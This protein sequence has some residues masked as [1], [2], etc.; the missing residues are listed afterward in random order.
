[1]RTMGKILRQATVVRDGF[2]NAFTDLQYWQSL[3]WVGYRK[4][5]GHV[6]M[7]GEIVIGVSADRARFREAARIKLYG[8][9]R[10][11]KLF[12]VSGTRCAVTIPTWEGG[13]QSGDL[14]QYIAFSEDGFHWSK[15]ERILADGEWLWRI[16][17]HKGLYYGLVQKLT[18]GK[19]RRLQHNLVLMTST[20]LLDWKTLCRIG[21]DEVGLNESDIVF[22]DDGSAWIVARSTKPPSY[23]YFCHAARPYT[24]WRITPLTAMIHAPI[25]LARGG[26]LFVAGRSNPALEGVAGFPTASSLGVWK[27]TFGAVE[28]VL[29]IPAMGDCSYP[30]LIRDPEGRICMTYYSQHAYLMGTVPCADPAAMPDDVYFAELEL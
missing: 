18:P 8:D 5:S 20:D 27:V 17:E 14:R 21:D 15:P 4:G 10:D 1:M 26:E 3:Y 9:N 12:P 7:D 30:G 2:H 6:S 29:R 25:M 24:E 13:Y 22:R 11:P 28:P 23:S 16:R 19:E